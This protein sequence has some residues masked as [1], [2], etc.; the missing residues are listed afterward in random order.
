MRTTVYLG[1]SQVR[2]LKILAAER[3]VTAS[4]LLRELID[5]LLKGEGR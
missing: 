2:G 1:R 3:G 5:R 4:E